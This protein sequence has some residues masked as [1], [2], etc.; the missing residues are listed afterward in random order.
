[1]EPSLR[2][3]INS[4]VVFKLGFFRRRWE[5]G[6]RARV[7]GLNLHGMCIFH[8]TQIRGESIGGIDLGMILKF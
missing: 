4:G 6:L 8:P 2:P 3:K 1:M 5:L 7:A